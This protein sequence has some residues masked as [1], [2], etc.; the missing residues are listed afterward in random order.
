MLMMS[1]ALRTFT[2]IHSVTHTVTHI[3][4]QCIEHLKCR[5]TFYKILY[6]LAFLQLFLT[7]TNSQVG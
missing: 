6:T 2:V 5:Y 3:V 1:L 7:I 4:T